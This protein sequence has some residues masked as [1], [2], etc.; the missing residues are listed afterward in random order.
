[1]E[2][3]LKQDESLRKIEDIL[4]DFTSALDEAIVTYNV[5]EEIE[6]DPKPNQLLFCHIINS[7]DSFIG[8][9]IEYVIFSNLD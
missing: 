3:E 7:F 2:N 6:E 5:L 8:Y 9:L 4:S 1:M